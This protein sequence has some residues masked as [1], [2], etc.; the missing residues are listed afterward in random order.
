MVTA[1]EKKEILEQVIKILVQGGQQRDVNHLLHGLLLRDS[2]Y[3]KLYKYRSFDKDGNSLKNLKNGT[4]HCSKPSDFN[5]LFECKNGVTFK[6]LYTTQF[7]QEL[8]LVVDIFH[9]FEDIVRGRLSLDDCNDD[10]RRII[11]QLLSSKKLMSFINEHINTNKTD[12]ELAQHLYDSPH[13]IVELLFPI[14]NDEMFGKFMRISADKLSRIITEISPEDLLVL[15]NKVNIQSIV[16]KEGVMNDADELSLT[17]SWCKKYYPELVDAVIALQKFI[18][19]F[20][21]RIVCQ[22]NETFLLGCLST[23]YKNRLMWSHYADCH[24]GFCIEYDYSQIDLTISLPF[25]VIYSEQRPLIPW[26]SVLQ[27]SPENI[28]EDNADLMF[29]LITKDSIWA[30]ENEWRIIIDSTECADFLMPK[31]SCVYLGAAIS[32]ENKKKIIEITKELGI[33]V[34]QMQLDRGAYDLHAEDI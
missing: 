2:N 6:S 4:L 22:I 26:R 17:I 31:V 23:D 16:H 28:A 11:N 8:D 27:S 19:G 30:Y 29:G 18:K 25:P 34:K 15:S 10:C 32:H 12:I 3:G 13:V 5:D 14:V 33:P 21:Q 20:A 24:K 9:A 7:N 1:E